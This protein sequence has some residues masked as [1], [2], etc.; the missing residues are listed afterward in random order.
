MKPLDGGYIFEEV[1][2]DRIESPESVEKL[3]KYVSILILLLV[4]FNLFI[5]DLANWIVESFA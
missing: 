3:T 2:K 5:V 1:L 4:I